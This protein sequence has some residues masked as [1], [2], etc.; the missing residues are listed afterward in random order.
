MSFLDAKDLNLSF[1]RIKDADLF[2]QYVEKAG[3]LMRRY[4]VKVF[5]RGAF[6]A[7]IA[8][9]AEAV[10]VGAVFR[11]RD[12]ETA[13]AFFASE[14]YRALLPLREAA[15]DMMVVLIPETGEAENERR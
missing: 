3:E 7:V 8:G 6:E 10:S 1:A 12:M 14:E 2:V 13:R 9:P 5:A 11:Y 15:C 4:D